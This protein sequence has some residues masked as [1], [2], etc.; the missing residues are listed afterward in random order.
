MAIK[1]QCAK[2]SYHSGSTC[3]IRMASPVYDMT[4][5]ENY[6]N[7]SIDLSKSR[8]SHKVENTTTNIPAPPQFPNG[9]TS[10]TGNPSL[11]TRQEKFGMFQT[12]FSFDGRIR[13]MEFGLS[14]IIYYA[15]A[16]L[17]GIVLGVTGIDS[18]SVIYMLLIPG[19]WFILAQGAKRCHDRGNSGWF[20][21]VPFYG[22]WMLFAD[23]D[24]FENDYGVDPKG[25]NILS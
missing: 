9:G 19:Y 23:G 13:R 7:C 11:E 16:F 12:P 10:G 8:D 22:L 15:Y 4:S 21:I 14:L 3:K 17:L 25:R 6:K 20:Q 2:C 1:D 18:N 24:E 5:C